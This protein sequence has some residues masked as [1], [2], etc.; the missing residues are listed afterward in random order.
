MRFREILTEAAVRI[1]SPQQ[2]KDAEMFGPMYHGTQRDLADIVQTGFNPKYS[3]PSAKLTG[4]NNRP[5]GT[6]NGMSLADIS[7]GDCQGILWRYDEG[8]THLLS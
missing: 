8:T 6:S 1:I 7:Q 2:A 3:V 4:W 5:V